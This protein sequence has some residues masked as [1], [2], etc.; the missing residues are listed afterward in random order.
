MRRPFPSRSPSPRGNAEY[1]ALAALAAAS[2][3]LS[4][5]GSKV[6][7]DPG[8]GGSG[9]AT[10]TSSTSSTS[11]SSSSSS[12]SSSSTSSTETFCL[13]ATDADCSG[14]LVCEACE[15]VPDDPCGG[16]GCEC[17]PGEITG[18]YSGP[19]GT[20]DVGQCKPGTQECIGGFW[21]P[22]EG[23]IVPSAEQCDG[24]DHDCDGSTALPDVDGDGWTVCDG[25]CCENAACSDH[26][27]RVNP[28]AIEYPGNQIDDDCNPATLDGDPYAT[29]SATAD[30]GPPSS[31]KLVKAM[32]LCVFTT[33]DPPL[34]QR[35]WGVI[36]ADLTLADGSPLPPP[37]NVQSGV[38]QTFG[39]NVPARYGQTMAALSSGTARALGDPDYVHP[40]NG[41]DP[42]QQMGN[43]N[44]QTQAPMPDD[45]L[46]ASGGAA[47]V[48]C[49]A[50][51][52]DG[53][54]TAHDSIALSIRLRVP[55]NTAYL[56]YDF[57]FYSA[58]YPEQV[59][60]EF[61]DFFVALLKSQ[62]PPGPLPGGNIAWDMFLNP[63]SVNNAFFDVCVGCSGGTLGLVGNGMGGWD[64]E[65]NQA[66]ATGWTRDIAQVIPGEKIDL[67]FV[68]WDSWDG[69]VDSLVLLDRV[70]FHVN[71]PPGNPGP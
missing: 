37:A 10:T 21:G 41:P 58:E 8:E 15:C 32:D 68:I 45:W 42:G 69:N 9:G 28:G 7:L 65:L 6:I 5:C 54:A 30:F 26:P 18:C 53:C 2:I 23:E 46:L 36:S 49:G 16:G 60:S 40:Q 50:C 3:G 4:A 39:P 25:D 55:T 20:E 19:P 63:V 13:C 22:C 27:E 57:D 66:G 51:A 33:E 11:T 44:A 43:Y 71:P 24:L 62:A 59:C 67:R 48:G 14:G 34:P 70:R 1:G 17:V 12:T 38:L 29:C 47:P 31:V 56:S 61:N 52:A 64:G 35:T